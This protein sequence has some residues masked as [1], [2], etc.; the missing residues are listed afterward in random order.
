MLNNLSLSKLVFYCKSGHPTSKLPRDFDLELINPYSQRISKTAVVNF[1]VP[2][3]VFLSVSFLVQ[4]LKVEEDPQM[5]REPTSPTP[6]MGIPTLPLQHFLEVPTLLRYSL[7]GKS[8]GEMMMTWRL[9]V[10]T[11]SAHSQASTSTVFLVIGMW[12][13]VGRPD[14]SRTQQ[15]I[16]SCG[17]RWR[18][19]FTGAPNV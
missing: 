5:A 15:S 10:G 19:C 13:L 12:A 11:L 4:V 8:T 17:F 9:M 16:M 14:A 3:V 7:G 2:F 6:S 18:K 1:L